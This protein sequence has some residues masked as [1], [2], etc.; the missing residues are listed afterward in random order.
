ME[1]V[2]TYHTGLYCCEKNRSCLI[3]FPVFVYIRFPQHLADPDN[4]L[5]VGNSLPCHHHNTCPETKIKNMEII[6][7][8]YYYEN[9]N[10][11]Y[12]H[13]PISNT[14]CIL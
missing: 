10:S 7:I 4:I 11:V 9:E 5:H 12:K 8:Y 3:R 2:L 14:E 6:I 1:M 13:L